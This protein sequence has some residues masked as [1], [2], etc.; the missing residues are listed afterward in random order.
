[1]SLLVLPFPLKSLR[2]EIFDVINHLFIPH[3]ERLRVLQLFVFC[4]DQFE[5]F[6]LLQGLVLLFVDIYEVDG[7]EQFEAGISGGFLHSSKYLPRVL[8]SGGILHVEDGFV[9]FEKEE[10]LRHFVV[11][12][13]FFESFLNGLHLPSPLVEILRYGEGVDHLLLVEKVAL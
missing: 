10:A 13:K 11:L 2:L 8:Q 4:K 7:A 6:Q 12:C 9:E 3:S 5:L 1:M